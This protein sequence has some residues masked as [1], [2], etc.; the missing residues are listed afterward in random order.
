MQVRFLSSAFFDRKTGQSCLFY[1]GF[2]MAAKKRK[3]HINSEKTGFAGFVDRYYFAVA[4][5]V[6]ALSV[7]ITF[8]VVF[9]IAVV[10]EN[11]EKKEQEIAN[12]G[13]LSE[14][15]RD[16]ALE[17]DAHP[18][19]NEV[20][21]AYH[22]ALADYDEEVIQKYLL[23]VNQNELDSI[24]V[25]S[26]YIESYDNITCYTQKAQA[27]GAY[28]V[29]V[30]Y[31]LKMKGYATKLPGMIGFYFCYDDAGN[32]K[33]CRQSDISEDVITDFYLAFSKQDVQDLFNKT[34]LAYNE[35]LDSDEDL[36][37]YM[38]GFDELVKQ[39][40]VK[41]IALRAATETPSEPVSEAVSEE[42]SEETNKS[43][44]V[45][46]TTAVNVRGSASEKG[47]LKGQ[48]SPGMRLTRVEEMINGWS[49]VIFNGADGYIKTEFLT[50]VSDEAAGGNTG[51]SESTGKFVTV[52][53]GVNIRA[54]ASKDSTAVAMADPGTKLELIEKKDGWCKIKYNGQI[55]YV[56]A[57]YVE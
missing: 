21:E 2:E 56:K 9:R 30:S 29:Y 40:M 23:Y 34:A 51:D 16:Y 45:E 31:N 19:V 39:E 37:T 28:Y 20:M 44:V 4:G 15:G 35:T 8:L 46:P 6:F 1:R 18:E 32:P 43:D 7:A 41:K 13:E 24:A 14:D 12:M 38:E 17:V 42:P 47:E 26:E 57:D 50:V 55:A 36:K 3:N 49:H 25:K 48:A 52:K 54:E 33:I 11:K 22:K 5:F 53:E 10:K 27:E